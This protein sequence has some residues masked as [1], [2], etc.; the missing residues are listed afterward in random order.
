MSVGNFK[1]W[2]NTSQLK[3]TANLLE[4]YLMLYKQNILI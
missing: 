4:K 3:R 2:L 1:D